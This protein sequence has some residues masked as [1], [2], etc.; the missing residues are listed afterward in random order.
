[1]SGAGKSTLSLL[2]QQRLEQAGQRTYVLDGDRLRDGLCRDLGFSAEDRAENIRRAAEVARLMVDA[3][4]VVLAA[5]ISPFRHE[6]ALARALFAPGQFIELFVDVPLAVAEARDP[7]G[8]Y[9]KA[10]SG[11]IREFTGIDSPYEPPLAP[12]LRLATDVH[13]PDELVARIIDYLSAN[14]YL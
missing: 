6:R 7:K 8:L 9:R 14:E 4:M 11:A 12:E 3:G 13:D 1:L 10:R 5:F 2:L